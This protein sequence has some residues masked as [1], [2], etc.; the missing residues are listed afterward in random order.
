MTTRVPNRARVPEVR[1][2]DAPHSG[3]L[4]HSDG[5]P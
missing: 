5:M 4:E 2:V 3:A 1:Q